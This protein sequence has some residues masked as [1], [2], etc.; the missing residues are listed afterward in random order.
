MME[1]F[2][3]IVWVFLPSLVL[4]KPIKL[5]VE[6]IASALRLKDFNSIVFPLKL[7]MVL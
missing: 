3:L 6:F 1:Y 4:S 7:L 5:K 2:H